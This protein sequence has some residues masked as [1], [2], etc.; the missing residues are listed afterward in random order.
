MHMYITKPQGVP[1]LFS[2]DNLPAKRCTNTLAMSTCFPGN[3]H[4]T[5]YAYPAFETKITSFKPFYLLLFFFY[6][7]VF[8]H[9]GFYYLTNLY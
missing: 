4:A 2:S 9:Y 1:C 7:L 6:T 8:L 3:V 5:E